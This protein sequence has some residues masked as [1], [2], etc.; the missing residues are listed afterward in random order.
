MYSI[1]GL[2]IL[3]LDVWAIVKTIN[4][5]ADNTTK[6]LWVLVI[7]VFPLIGFIAWFLAGPGNGKFRT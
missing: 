2:L 5:S 4:G 7:L 6:I 3:I 1:I